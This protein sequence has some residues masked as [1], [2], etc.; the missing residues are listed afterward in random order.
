MEKRSRSTTD[1]NRM[2]PRP[3]YGDEFD[4]L[5]EDG[6]PMAG[7]AYRGPAGQGKDHYGGMSGAPPPATNGYPRGQTTHA[8]G[9]M[10]PSACKSICREK[11]TLQCSQSTVEVNS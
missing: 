8:H 7:A 4:Q 10:P 6:L 9:L 5:D 3:D 1:I 2:L 11:N